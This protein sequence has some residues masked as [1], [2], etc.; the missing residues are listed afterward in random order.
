MEIEEPVYRAEDIVFLSCMSVMHHPSTNYLW[1]RET[2]LANL[3]ATSGAGARICVSRS[4]IAK[5]TFVSEQQLESRLRDLGFSI[6]RPEEHSVD[7]Q[8]AMFNKARLIVGA[9]GAA[10]AN[11]LY[12]QPGATIVEIQPT[13]MQKNGMWVACIFA[14]NGCRWRPYFCDSFASE[15]QVVA[16]RARMEIGFSFDVD[17][18]DFIAYLA[19]VERAK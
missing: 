7:E 10:F 8:I 16:G 17:L 12:C 6:V 2:K 15:L 19:A 13:R 4:G 1:L 5:R 18:D 11:V 14:L 3:A 9:S